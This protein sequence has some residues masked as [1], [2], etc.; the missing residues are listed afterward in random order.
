MSGQAVKPARPREV[1]RPKI[2]DRPEG[3]PYSGVSFHIP[4]IMPRKWG[5]CGSRTRISSPR[6]GR[7]LCRGIHSPLRQPT[8][9]LSTLGHSK[10]LMTVSG[11][12]DKPNP[13]PQN[14]HRAGRY[15]CYQRAQMPCVRDTHRTF[16][17]RDR[18]RF[19]T[20]PMLNW[21]PSGLGVETPRTQVRMVR[22]LTRFSK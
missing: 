13:S 22:H 12:R 6:Q 9:G 11:D 14:K 17:R 10:R 8:R 21:L 7:Y 15:S 19:H 3:L 20:L 16:V 4:V 5:R 2:R 1:L 18:F